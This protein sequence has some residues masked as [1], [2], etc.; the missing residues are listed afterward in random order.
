MSI[1]EG[2][3]TAIFIVLLV[4]FILVALWITLRILSAVVMKVEKV[5]GVLKS[6]KQ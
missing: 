1:F 4:F 6:S 3:G 2:V 5:I